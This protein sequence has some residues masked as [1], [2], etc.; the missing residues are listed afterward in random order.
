MALSHQHSGPKHPGTVPKRW[1]QEFSF[2]AIVK[3]IFGHF[4]HTPGVK[5]FDVAHAATQYKYVGVNNVD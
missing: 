2:Q 1:T 4:F 3:D 5:K